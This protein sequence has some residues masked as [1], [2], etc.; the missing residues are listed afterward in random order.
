MLE[1]LTAYLNSD[2]LDELRRT[3][4]HVLS[5]N[6]VHGGALTMRTHDRQPITF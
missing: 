6:L 3:A 1:I 5:Q 2:A 4:S